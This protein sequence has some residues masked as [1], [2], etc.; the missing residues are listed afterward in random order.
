[1]ALSSVFGLASS[2]FGLYLSYFFG[3]PPGAT[4]V[5]VATSLFVVV[6]A[7]QGAA[8]QVGKHD[9]PSAR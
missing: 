5:L 3:A 8:G 6:L 4:V 2:I 7:L 9:R 1:M